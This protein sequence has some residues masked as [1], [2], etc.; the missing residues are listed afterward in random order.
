MF[1]KNSHFTLIVAI[2][3]C[4]ISQPSLSASFDCAKARTRV[5]KTICHEPQLDQADEQLGKAYLK[6]RKML[7]RAEANE[8]RRE[9]RAW[10]EQRD[11]DCLINE[12]DCLLQMY[13][14]RIA[15][16]TFRVSPHFNTGPS[17]QISGRYTIDDYMFMNVVPLSKERVFIEI[18]GAEPVTVRWI[19]NFSGSGAVQDN[20]VLI[21]HRHQNTP[22]TF[23]FS[24]QTVTV[25]GEDLGDF[26][27]F[28]GSIAGKYV[29][30]AELDDIL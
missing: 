16:L 24:E 15:M 14:D 3:L 12:V 29:K 17:A 26:C 20:K 1:E 9:Q 10:L 5:E 22:I 7:P 11:S 21:S 13:Q 4:F 2:G 19:C 28:G 30:I 18:G 25:S 23:N 8:L 6:L 27:G